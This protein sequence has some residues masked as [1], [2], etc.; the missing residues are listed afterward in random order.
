MGTVSQDCI[1]S[2]GKR[3]VQLPSHYSMY[4]SEYI[5]YCIEQEE[6]LRNLEMSL[7][8]S[9]NPLIISQM[10]MKQACDFYGADWAGFFI[11]DFKVNIWRP[12]WWYNPNADRHMDKRVL[13]CESTEYLE[14]WGKAMK[15]N[16]PIS[17]PDTSKM[18]SEFPEEYELYL[19]MKAKSLLA[20]P[21]KPSPLGFFVLRNPKR[22][23][24]RSGTLRHLT[25]VGMLAIK[26]Q[27]FLESN[28]YICRPEDIKTDKEFIINVFGGLEIHSSQGVLK[29]D[30]IKSPRMCRLLVYLLINPRISYS[31]RKIA[32]DI[33]TEY[34]LDIEVISKNIRGL[35]YRFRQVFS[36][37]SN[38]PLIES[39][40]NGYRLNPELH[41]MTDMDNFEKARTNI[42]TASGTAKKVELIKKALAIYKGEIYPSASGEH[43]LAAASRS[44]SFRYIGLAHELL[45]KLADAQEWDSVYHYAAQAV[46]VLPGNVKAY[47]WLIV[48]MYKSGAIE[49]AL[50]EVEHAKTILI[51][52]EFHVLEKWLKDAAVDNFVHINTFQRNL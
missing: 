25:H 49:L 12:Y 35:I 29:E 24:D 6:A 1:S 41:I 27:M 26:E 43:W 47:F 2:T 45:A 15:E 33:W 30:D 52:E 21:F 32:E 37:I 42:Q 51:P 40:S 5:Q 3:A 17:I 9:D 23:L 46:T 10:I 48:G 16:L 31:P 36:L 14:R 38:Y 7:T 34:D 50:N 13:E 19:R 39:T 28:K 18:Q 8:K 44:Y 11:I 22:Y 4:S 20:V